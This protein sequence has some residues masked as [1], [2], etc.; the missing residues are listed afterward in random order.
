MGSVIIELFALIGTLCRE[1]LVSFVQTFLPP[2]RKDINGEIVFVTGAGSG[3]G[4]LMAIK[5]AKL[6]AT[7]VCVDI[8]QNANDETV[9]EIKSQGFKA[10]GYI[11][12]CSSREDIYRVAELV[13]KDVGDVTMLVNN[14][15]IVSGKKFLET[16][17][18][19]IQKTMEINTMAHFWTTK[20]FLPSMV[21]KNHGH[22]VSIASS[23]GFFGVNG[24]CDYCSSKYGAVGFNESL[25]MELGV[26]KKDGVHTT[27]ICP[28]YINTGMFD[29]VKTRF[30][31]LMPILEPEWATD[32]MI[33]AVL[34]NK[35]ELLLPKVLKLHLVIKSV[36]PTTSYLSLS[37]FFGV[38]SSM[39]EFKGREK[40]I[41]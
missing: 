28:F 8:N 7:L 13:K 39:D 6:G 14:A 27:V 36:L 3:L 15:G 5:F 9:Q 10:H 21:E 31:L 26:L 40:K 37:R 33:D 22:V 17:D 11:C 4:R 12:D 16:E 2:S 19:K 1:M 20:A 18:W 35:T 38:S 30:P 41:N 23:A 29:G 32:Q 25:N 34:R 24:L